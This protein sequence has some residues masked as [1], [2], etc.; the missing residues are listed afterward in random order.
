MDKTK[1]KKKTAKAKESQNGN[2]VTAPQKKTKKQKTR[3]GG[4]YCCRD[5][6]YEG[7]ED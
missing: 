5:C 6:Q 3:K 1:N 2:V 7:W 4:C